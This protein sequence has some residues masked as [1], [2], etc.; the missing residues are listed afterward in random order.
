MIAAQNSKYDFYLMMRNHIQFNHIRETS[1]LSKITILTVGFVFLLPIL[2]LLVVVGLVSSVIFG[3]LL[4]I[5]MI[6]LKLRSLTGRDSQ[7][8]KNVRIKR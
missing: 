1:L 6:N 8:R 3:T 2:L 4:L 5:G 7:G